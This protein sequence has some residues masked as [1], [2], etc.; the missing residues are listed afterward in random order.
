MAADDT[1]PPAA[2]G[3]DGQ[4]AGGIDERVTRLEAGQETM[5]GQLERIIGMLSGGDAPKPDGQPAAAAGHPNIGHEIR[6]QLDERDARA[7]AKASADEQASTIAS[8][9][10][11]V[12][13]LTEA[14]PVAP[15]RRAT[16]IMWGSD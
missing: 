3:Q 1:T 2:D 16:K 13:Q 4:Q 7:R 9:Q 14:A 5:S 6:A 11:T 10:E 8:L 12:R 15:V